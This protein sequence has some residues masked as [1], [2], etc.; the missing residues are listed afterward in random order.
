M[1]YEASRP[2]KGG[3]VQ[4]HCLTEDELLAFHL[5]TLPEHEVEAA[6]DHLEE[7]PRCEAAF[8]RYDTV[9]DP[10]LNALRKDPPA[11]PPHSSRAG[12][13][14]GGHVD[15]KPP[16][17]QEGPSLPGYEI[18]GP[19]G[20][21][22]MGVVY[23][24]LQLR[25]N[26]PVAL[27]RLQ[28]GGD[29]EAARAKVE[30]EALA[31]LQ[32]PNVVQIHEVIEHNDTTYLALELVEGGPLSAR[33]KG[34]PPPPRATAE[35]LETVARAVHYAHSLGIIHRD[36]KPANILLAAAH[37]PEG[38][39]GGYGIPKVADFGVAKRLAA[40]SG[41]T[42]TGD[43]IGT[44]S[45]MAP[46]QAGAFSARTGPAADVYS[47][48]VILYEML[49]GHVPI[50]GTTALETLAL[51]RT[52]EPV[53][54]RRLQPRVP[55]DLETICLK[56]LAK[57]PANRYAGA[58]ELADDLRRF[59]RREPIHARPAGAVERVWRWCRRNPVPA[60]LLLAVTLGSAMG[61][62]HLSGLSEQFVRSTALTSASMQADVLEKVNARYS[63]VVDRVHAQE[64]RTE[65]PVPA[66][67]LTDVGQDVSGGETGMLVRHYSDYPFKSRKDGGP[68]D[69]LEREALTHLRESPDEPYFRFQ[70][71]Q[72]RPVLR[73]FTA[74]RMRATCV[75]C[76]NTH[77]DSTKTDWRTGDVRGVLEIVHPL[78]RDVARAREGL[79]GTFLLMAGVSGSLLGL[80]GMALFVGKRRKEALSS[81]SRL[82]SQKT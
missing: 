7:C 25:L 82:T 50:Q 52:E 37:H 47:L 74:R 12:T 57:K 19:I 68:K 61:L 21:G 39:S 51:V 22:G 11:S 17:R 23:K 36:L 67:F 42:Q 4:R 79:R 10:V 64:S 55:R 81:P 8:R 26:R 58:G 44:P 71:F 43:V 6:A 16:T 70:E 29:R 62:W 24:A 77:P 28:S 33:L 9:V 69:D 30:A 34:R 18:L 80:A 56:C 32:H 78:D 35:L 38:A 49:T 60:G 54:P 59:L 45:Y 31:H 1:S 76:H 14:V 2:K 75:E 40:E 72:G 65:M 48:G 15:P 63:Q 46:E 13:E 41:A 3:R 20:R 27:K 5:G 53:P 73:Y 66:K